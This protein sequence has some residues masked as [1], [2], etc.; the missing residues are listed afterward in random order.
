MND[1]KAENRV[2]RLAQPEKDEIHLGIA[3][4][5]KR[6]DYGKICNLHQEEQEKHWKLLVH[7]AVPQDHRHHRLED[8]LRAPQIKGNGVAVPSHG[9]WG[10]VRDEPRKLAAPQPF[11][12]SS[13]RAPLWVNLLR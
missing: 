5:P 6:K 4:E 7:L 3:D 2:G 10:K 11:P 13:G 8:R 9:A 1:F 12:T